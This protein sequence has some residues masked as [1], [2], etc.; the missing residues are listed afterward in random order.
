MA[1]GIDRTDVF[2]EQTGNVTRAIDRDRVKGADEAGLLGADRYAGSAI[3][4][5]I[6]S[7][8]EDDGLLLTHIFLNSEFGLK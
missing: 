8:S 6:P 1:N 3:Y 4:A 7:D 2:A 5:G